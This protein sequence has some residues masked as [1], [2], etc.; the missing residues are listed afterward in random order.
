[1]GQVATGY[2]NELAI[3]VYGARGALEWKQARPDVLHLFPFGQPPQTITRMGH[4]A[5]P[6]VAAVSRI[7]PGHVEGYLEA[8]ANIY[9]GCAELIT[10]RLE[11]REPDPAARLVPS[12]EDGA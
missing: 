8:F 9:T 4:G 3:G 5:G 1:A 6:A 2:E 7:P 12:V 11:G 10:A